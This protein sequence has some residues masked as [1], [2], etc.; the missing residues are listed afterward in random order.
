MHALRQQAAAL[1]KPDQIVTVRNIVHHPDHEHQGDADHETE[2]KIVV[3]VFAGD[4]DPGEDFRAEQRD[5]HIA[6]IEQVQAGQRQNDEGAGGQPV[7][8]AL[9]A[10]KTLD[11]LI[12]GAGID[13]DAAAQ[14]EKQR[15][16]TDDADQR[17]NAIG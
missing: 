7:H 9:K 17:P 3:G 14:E 11:S 8:A 16:E 12:A 6:A 1:Q 13:P 10:G 15:Q 4:G 5:Q 2:S